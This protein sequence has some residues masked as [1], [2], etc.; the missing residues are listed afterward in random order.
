MYICYVIIIG[1]Y[2]RFEI[3]VCILF[4]SYCVALVCRNDTVTSGGFFRCF[5]KID[6]YW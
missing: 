4:Y 5:F 6:E 3:L 1:K 2:V